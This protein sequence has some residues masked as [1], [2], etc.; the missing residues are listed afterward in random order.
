MIYKKG[1][2]GRWRFGVIC[3]H[4]VMIDARM[5]LKQRFLNLNVDDKNQ[6]F[7]TST[8]GACGLG[9]RNEPITRRAYSTE[10]TSKFSG[11]RLP[12]CQVMVDNVP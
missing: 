12:I 6:Y 8:Q 1:S 3:L 7:S 2:I 11:K 10:R 5:T 9:I 4:S